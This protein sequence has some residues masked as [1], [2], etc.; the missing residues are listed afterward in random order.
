[1][2]QQKRNQSD[3]QQEQSITANGLNSHSNNKFDNHSPS[4]L[5]ELP[6]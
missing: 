3:E 2:W 6:F 1:M 5:A 4:V